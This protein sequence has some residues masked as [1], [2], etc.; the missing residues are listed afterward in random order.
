MATV[1][2][3]VGDGAPIVSVEELCV[4]YGATV[5]LEDVFLSAGRGEFVSIIGKSGSGKSTLLNAIAG[6]V[7]Y[8]GDITRPSSF[9]YV[10]QTN[11]LFP[12]MDVWHN[13]AF[14]LHDSTKEMRTELVEELLRRTEMWELRFRYPAEL[15]GGQVQRAA[16]ARALAPDPDVLLMDEPYGALDFHTREKMQDWLLTLWK[17]MRKTVIFVTHSI[18]EALY[19][20]DRVLILSDGRL[21]NGVHVPFPR[22]RERALRFSDEYI[23]H[24]KELL[25]RLSEG[26]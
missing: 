20:S 5:V 13:V 2:D 14:G 19:L 21:E 1:L 25:G 11:A 7:E 22:P 4:T 12:W 8:T 24:K 3:E 26:T 6:F 9:G 17:D 18:D 16:L 15:S 23:R 10:F